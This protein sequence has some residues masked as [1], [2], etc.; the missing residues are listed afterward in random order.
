MHRA[1]CL[2]TCLFTLQ[3]VQLVVVK[4]RFD[5]FTFV[6]VKFTIYSPPSLGWLLDCNQTPNRVNSHF[7]PHDAV[8]VTS[9]AKIRKHL[10]SLLT[11][12]KFLEWQDAFRLYACTLGVRR[13]IWLKRERKS[14]F[15]L[16]HSLGS[17]TKFCYSCYRNPHQ[18]HRNLRLYYHHYC[19]IS[20]D[21][22]FQER[23]NLVVGLIT[24]LGGDLRNGEC[25]VLW[26]WVIS[27]LD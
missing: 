18:C 22:Y 10:S 7:L 9:C 25:I 26:L 24:Q 11:A 27:P 5:L 4:S 17:R 2:F 23:I 16:R 13:G 20:L 14:I 8:H 21:I 15:Q 1:F 3:T 19:S 12:V 6:H